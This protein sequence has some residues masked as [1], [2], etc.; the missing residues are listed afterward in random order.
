MTK[1][2]EVEKVIKIKQGLYRNHMHTFRP[3]RKHVQ[4]FKKIG[5]KLYEE[6]NLQGT[7]C[8]YIEVKK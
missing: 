8:L 3:L 2:H 5:I 6:M 1:V 7:H 4:N